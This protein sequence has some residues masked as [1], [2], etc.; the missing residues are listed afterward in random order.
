MTTPFLLPFGSQGDL[1]PAEAP[2]APPPPPVPPGRRAFAA[3]PPLAGSAALLGRGFAYPF[4]FD[5]G[6][7]G[8]GRVA[9]VDSVRASLLRLFDTSPGEE[10][11]NPAYG[12]ALKELLFEPDTDV[13]RALAETTI[14]QAV[15][16]WEPRIA[17]VF[18]VDVEGV[19]GND[20]ALRLRVYFRLIESQVVDNFV[21]P[22][23]RAGV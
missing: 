8:S 18:R 9:G 6:T 16:R 3:E 20:H 10:F 21:Y 7:G 15:A 13:L 11:M 2:A 5:A 4:A 12:C 17:E 14:R 23:V 1:T 19:P 22:F